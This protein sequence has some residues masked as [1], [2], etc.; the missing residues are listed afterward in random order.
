MGESKPGMLLAG[1]PLIEYPLS[2]ARAAGLEPWVLTKPGTILPELDCRI[3]EEPAEP[4]DPLAGIVT[5]LEADPSRPV[6]AL[7]ADMPFLGEWLIAWLA[8]MPVTTVTEYS[9]AIHPLLAR[10]EHSDAG[11]LRVSLDSGQPAA[12]A[13]M[14]L[15]PKIVPETDLVRFGDPRMLTFTVNTPADLAEA[16]RIAAARPAA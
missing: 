15:R 14:A 6:I 3:I 4:V 16:E 10:Y 8:T 5:A 12:E 2:A 7:G 13:V 1:T 11:P 9:G